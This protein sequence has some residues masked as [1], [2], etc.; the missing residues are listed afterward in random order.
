MSAL[1][2]LFRSSW[3]AMCSAERQT[4]IS[5]LRR[6]LQPLCRL[7]SGCP[8]SWSAFPRPWKFS[9]EWNGRVFYGLSVNLLV[10]LSPVDARNST[11][12]VN[13]SDFW[14]LSRSG[15]LLYA[16]HEDS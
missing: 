16:V 10:E 4:S 8:D 11:S 7:P 14:S 12:F 13:T 15:S 2:H 9:D 6:N 1:I 5:R 3:T